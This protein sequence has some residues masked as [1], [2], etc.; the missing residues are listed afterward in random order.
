MIYL[1]SSA[2]LKLLFEESDSAA[3]ALWLFGTGRYSHA[4]QR[5]RQG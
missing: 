3:L 1:D 2:L 5:T 4:E